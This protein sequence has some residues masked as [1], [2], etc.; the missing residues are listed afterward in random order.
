VLFQNNPKTIAA[1]VKI[2]RF[3]LISSEP[4]VV[5]PV[6]VV[7]LLVP[8]ED[9]DELPVEQYLPFDEQSYVISAG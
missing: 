4:F 5:P 7:V 9:E 3:I 1:R 2:P 8:E 6:P